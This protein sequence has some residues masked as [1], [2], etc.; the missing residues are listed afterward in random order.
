MREEP[1]MISASHCSCAADEDCEA[2]LQPIPE[3]QRTHKVSGQFWIWAG[4]NLAPINWVL[5]ALGI[6]LGLGFAD[7]VT[8]LVLG[9]LI[10]M[11]LFG[12]FVLLGQK[13]GAT[14]MVLARAAFG[15]RGNYLPAAIQALLGHRLVRRQ[16]LDHPGPGDGAV[17]HPRLG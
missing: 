13:T 15:R 7:T 12:C 16:H 14:G 11:L 9:N 5:G 10:G 4:A 3:S 6:H 8:V 2:W 1:P 17:R